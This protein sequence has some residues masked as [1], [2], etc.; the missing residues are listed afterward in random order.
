M[1]GEAM[2]TQINGL[3]SAWPEAVSMKFAELMAERPKVV[4]T[5]AN[6]YT[7][8]PYVDEY[9]RGS[10]GHGFVYTIAFRHVCLIVLNGKELLP[11]PAAERFK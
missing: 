1:I 11:R 5:H 7:S 4:V 9:N 3:D 8:R 6:Y 10:H 2:K